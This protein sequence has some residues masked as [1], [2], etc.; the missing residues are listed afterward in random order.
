MK[1]S[2]VKIIP[3][4]FALL[5]GASASADTN[6][7]TLKSLLAKK[8]FT[9]DRPLITF[10][11][12]HRDRKITDL[13]TLLNKVKSEAD[14]F[15][16]PNDN[17]MNSM[18]GPG[19]YVSVDPAATRA[20]YGLEIPQLYVITLK[21]GTRVIDVR[22]DFVGADAVAYRSIVKQL[23][24]SDGTQDPNP[25]TL[26]LSNNKEC[27]DEVL[28]TYEE[29]GIE[30]IL[31]QFPASTQIAGCRVARE[32]AFN[33]IKGS[34]FQDSSFGFYSNILGL[35]TKPELR[36]LVSALFQEASQDPRLRFEL[37]EILP[38]KSLQGENVVKD[39]EYQ[40][41]KAQNIW[42]CGTARAGES[43]VDDEFLTSAIHAISGDEF[44]NELIQTKRA[45]AKYFNRAEFDIR[46][47]R[48]ILQKQ[49]AA[50]RIVKTP[51][52][53]WLAAQRKLQYLLSGQVSSSDQKYYNMMEEVFKVLQEPI[54]EKQ[55]LQMQPKFSKVVKS[56]M[57]RGK[58]DIYSKDMGAWAAV[59]KDHGFGPRST[60]LFMNFT[61]EV[62]F[63]LEVAPSADVEDATAL[64]SQNRKAVIQILRHCRAIYTEASQPQSQTEKGLCGMERNQTSY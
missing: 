14:R 6:Q 48:A 32:E 34:A 9:L 15:Y 25:N 1:N 20:S 28:K 13:S 60:A 55:V 5:A 63:I 29:L 26:R 21:A 4:F 27:R 41:W 22:D 44:T 49:H 46:M 31:Y 64:V 11:Y 16:D 50:M 24:C 40:A 30:A 61:L 57:P 39:S 52:S 58:K 54:P 45:Y 62:P 59:Y 51:Y 38:L 36:P 3:L 10:H 2:F 8:L 17:P 12:K 43:S 35:E 33:V 18:I 19:L 42:K 47:L 7:P 53:E 56:K 23:K 37:N